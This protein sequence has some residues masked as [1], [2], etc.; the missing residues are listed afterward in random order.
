MLLAVEGGGDD[1]AL[2]QQLRE[3]LVAPDKTGVAQQLVIEACVEEMQD[4]ML[5]A[6]DV[7]IDRQPIAGALVQHRLVVVGAR[8]AG[9]VPG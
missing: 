1:H 7:L 9:E 8:V 3:G 6:A 5:D 2:G 4:G